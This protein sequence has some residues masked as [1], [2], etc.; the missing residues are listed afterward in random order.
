MI[1]ITAAQKIGVGMFVGYFCVSLIFG[2]NFA[3]VAITT[4]AIAIDNSAAEAVT[5]HGGAINQYAVT[6]IQSA[7][8]PLINANER[9]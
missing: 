5:T 9:P 3:L 8:E 2:P 4:P 7:C 1:S 6:Q